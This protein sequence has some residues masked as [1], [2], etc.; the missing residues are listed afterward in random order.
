MPSWGQGTEVVSVEGNTLTL[1]EPLTW[2][3]N[4]LNEHVI[5]LRKQDGSVSGTYQVLPGN[6]AKSS[7]HSR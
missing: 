7:H 4:K 1:S 3:E 2:D 5:G 6:N